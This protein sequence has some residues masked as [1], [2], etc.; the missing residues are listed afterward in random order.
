[1]PISRTPDKTKNRTDNFVGNRGRRIVFIPWDPIEGQEWAIKTAQWNH[2]TGIKYEI[3]HYIPGQRSYFLATAS[4]QTDCSIYIRGHGNPGVPYIQVKVGPPEAQEARKLFISEACQ[5]LIDSGLKSSFPGVIK[6]FHCHSATIFTASA[7]ADEKARLMSKNADF[8]AA[9]KQNM[10]TAQQKE[11]W[12]VDIHKNKSIAR[13]GADYL[14]KK[15]FNKCL[16][17]GY[18][19]PLASEYDD[20]GAGGMHKMAELDGLENRPA[21]LNNLTTSRAS[22]A[23]VQV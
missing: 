15:G 10:I 18:L 6:F 14:R 5:R 8:E 23:R 22:Q 17:Y 11:D 12:T 1:M 13:I 4:T 9:Y 7:Y 20:D 16:F 3:V 2:A 21:A 19:G